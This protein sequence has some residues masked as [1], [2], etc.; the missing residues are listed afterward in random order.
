MSFKSVLKTKHIIVAID[1]F[2][3]DD[4]PAPALFVE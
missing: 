1:N 2:D 3:G 4:R